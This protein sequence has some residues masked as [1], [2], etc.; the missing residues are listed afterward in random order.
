[1]FMKYVYL[2]NF[3]VLDGRHDWNFIMSG[4]RDF[5][6][7]GWEWKYNFF[8]KLYR[9]ELITYVDISSIH[10]SIEWIQSQ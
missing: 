7:I 6:I 2:N 3:A 4:I 5:V 9:M 1:M 10:S 8:F